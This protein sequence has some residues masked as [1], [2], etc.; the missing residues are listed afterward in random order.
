[1]IYQEDGKALMYESHDRHF[2]VRARSIVHTLPLFR[3]VVAMCEGQVIH[4][5]E[6]LGFFDIHVQEVPITKGNFLVL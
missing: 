2:E 3:T 1:M 6:E 4:F 5:F